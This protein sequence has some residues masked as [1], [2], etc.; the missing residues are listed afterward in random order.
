MPSHPPPLHVLRGLLR[1]LKT[2]PLPPHLAKKQIPQR[3][4]PV[5]QYVLQQYRTNRQDVSLQEV[6]AN[7]LQLKKN[8]KERARLYALDTGAEEVLTP[9]EMSRRAAA[10][11]GLQLPK[12]DDIPI[13]DNK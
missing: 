4:N 2:P 3:L 13:H 7:Y 10:R 9:K 1:L 6:A 8:L 5:Q 11:A 12:L